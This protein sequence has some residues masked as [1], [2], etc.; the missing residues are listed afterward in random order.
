MGTPMSLD[1]DEFHYW[2]GLLREDI[3]EVKD[4]LSALNGRTRKAETDIAVLQDRAT[5]KDTPA[6]AAGAA[7]L[8]ATAATLF[9]QWVSKP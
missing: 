4:H 7:S 5:P 3:A 1:R 6:R 8:L 2:M 9:W